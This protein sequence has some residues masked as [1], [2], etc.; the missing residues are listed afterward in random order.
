[1]HTH[2]KKTNKL[3]SKQGRFITV[4]T[5]IGVGAAAGFMDSGDKRPYTSYKEQTGSLAQNLG[6]QTVVVHFKTHIFW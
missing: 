6:P 2:T 3:Q 4:W 5:R 1:M